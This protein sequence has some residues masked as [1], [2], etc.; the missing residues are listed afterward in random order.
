MILA[1]GSARGAEKNSSLL[2]L[3]EWR[4]SPAL[5]AR[6]LTEGSQR[7]SG[8]V[9]QMAFGAG[10]IPAAGEGWTIQKAEAL[11]ATLPGVISARIVGRPGGEIEEVHLLTTREVSPKQT[12]R[13]AESAL[14]AHFDLTVD[15]RKI[16]V[17]QSSAS[18]PPES[19]AAPA[20]R[21]QVLRVND[22]IPLSSGGRI[23]F[24]R[25]QA[26]TERSRQARVGVTLSWGGVEFEGEAVGADVPRSRLDIVAKATL[27]A[28]E[29]ILNQSSGI[30]SSPAIAL[31]LEGVKLIEALDRDYVL[32]AVNAIHE[33]EVTQLAGASPVEDSPE[34]AVVLATLQA[35]DRWV[36][37]R[38]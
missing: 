35:T 21:R 12:V 27:Q 15:H 32:V 25:Y 4:V 29:Q 34:R 19:A 11:L 16:S 5:R 26:E 13:N 37:G 17:A 7:S 30:P 33:R 24:T 9:A 8:R 6:V 28:M 22:P 23:L 2:G 20:T 36:R 3:S 14:K 18:R 10:E 1:G 31:V 38:L